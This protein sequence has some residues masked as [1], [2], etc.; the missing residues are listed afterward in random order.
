MQKY[1]EIQKYNY[2]SAVS[3]NRGYDN[4]GGGHDSRT[5]EHVA[6][7]TGHAIIIPSLTLSATLYCR[8]LGAE[9]GVEQVIKLIAWGRMS[10]CNVPMVRYGMEWYGMVWYCIVCKSNVS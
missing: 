4:R 8:L 3:G 9:W 7:T 10:S 1:S 2:T 5:S 6:S